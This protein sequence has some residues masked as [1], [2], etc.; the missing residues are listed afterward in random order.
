[1]GHDQWRCWSDERS[2][3]VSRNAVAIG[4]FDGVHLGHRRVLS[5]AT[6][7]C[8]TPLVVVTFWPHPVSVLRP[9]EA[10]K[11]ISDLHT[12]I[13][14]LKHAGAHEVRVIHF[15]E[16]VA[17]L[18]PA[19][20]VTRFLDPLDPGCVVVG[21]NFRF[22][23][24]AGG[25]VATLRDLGEGRFQVRALPLTT[26]G[27]SVT[28]STLV[29]D[30]LAEGNV[31]LAALHLGRPYRFHGVVVMG[32]QRGRDLGFP[33]AN[34]SVD[35]HWAVPADGVY[36]GWVTPAGGQAM[37]AA[38]SVGSNPTFDGIDRRVEAHVL[39]RADLELYGV[40][41]DVDFIARLR[42]Q[43]RFDGVDA[44]IAQMDAD[45]AAARQALSES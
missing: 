40:E 17:A 22:G 23:H 13:E 27:E 19:E 21:Q 24:Q 44:L 33:T 29:R 15:D 10:P 7:L 34:L 28:C 16:R 6:E 41:I 14:L 8:G 26:V 1:M 45:V 43:V 2:V 39:D 11:L 31:G 35:E 12:R 38:I 5:A 25:D 3:R 30:A 4:N 9:A 20:F 32:D 42:G 18:R 37:P 36:A